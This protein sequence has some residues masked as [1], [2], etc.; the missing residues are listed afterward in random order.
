MNVRTFC[1]T[2]VGFVL[3]SI[4]ASTRAA[5]LDEVRLAFAQAVHQA[6]P[7]YI[8]QRNPQPLLRAVV[9]LNIKLLDD[10]HWQA[11][12]VRTNEQQPEMLQRAMDTVARVRLPEVPADL[13]EDLQRNGIYETWLFDKDG[14]FQVKTLAKAQLSGR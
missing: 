8:H 7:E 3:A 12:V 1:F 5:N 11:E 9:V 10:D 6:S 13:R 14:S 2:C 4:A